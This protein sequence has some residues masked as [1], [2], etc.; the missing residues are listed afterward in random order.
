MQC[1]PVNAEKFCRFA[2]I[3]IGH[4]KGDLYGFRLIPG[5]LFIINRLFQIKIIII[6]NPSGGIPGFAGININAKKGN[7]ILKEFV[8]DFQ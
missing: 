1:A 7:F 3:P 6:R 2:F 4:K 5:N 8:T